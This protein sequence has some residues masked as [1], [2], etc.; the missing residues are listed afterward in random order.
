MIGLKVA[1]G[2]LDLA[3]GTISMEINN[4]LFDTESVPGTITYP[5]ALV[6]SP[7]NLV[8]LNFPHLR[9]DQGERVAPEPTEFYIDGVLRWV[10][11]LVYLEH[12]EERAQLLYNFVAEAADLQSRIVGRQLRQLELGEVP[13]VLTHDAPDYALPCLVNSQ[14]YEAEKAPGYTGVV[15]HYVAGAYRPTL[16]PGNGAVLHAPIVPFLRLVPLLRRVLASV[17]YALS[18]E[19]LDE[20]EVQALVIYSTRA[21]EDAD[22]V[23]LTTLTLNQYV[24]AIDV[25]TLLVGLQKFFG[26][27]YSFHP[28]RREL[29]IRALRDVLADPTYQERTGGPAR[30]MAV[31]TQGFVLTMNTPGDDLDQSL[32][33]E[34][35]TL[36]VG[37]GQQELSVDVG[38]L[39]VQHTADPIYPTREWF[40]P[41]VE[42]K[43]ASLAYETGDDA[44]AGLF[45]LL[46]RGLQ[47]DKQGQLYPL[48]TWGRENGDGFPV[49]SSSL[50]WAGPQGLYATWHQAWLDFLDRA[51]TRECTAQLRVA[52]LLTLDPTRKDMVN[53]K[54]YLWE[55]VSLSLSTTGKPLETAQF[56]YRYCRL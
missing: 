9:A 8:R 37:E 31:T 16:Y 14:F 42:A 33:T 10:G 39:H 19:W 29:R 32:G 7:D 24:P 46:D 54:K 26:L 51:T 3:A 41:C 20:P 35:A 12:D 2:W 17:G 18:G 25:A 27:A 6:L 36:R 28:V 34:W 13:L 53:G 49:G 30:S 38:T 48:A 5:F 44:S 15:N 52:D 50:R 22:G 23:L 45:L 40:V 56:T 43:G 55:K 47:P 11:S 4:P 1:A 21:A